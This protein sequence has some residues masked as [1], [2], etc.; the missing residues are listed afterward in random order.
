MKNFKE[1][2]IPPSVVFNL[3]FLIAL[4]ADNPRVAANFPP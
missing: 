3:P 4:R 2:I 1:I